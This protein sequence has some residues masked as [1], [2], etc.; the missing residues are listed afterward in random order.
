MVKCHL[1]TIA[2]DI[3][4]NNWFSFCFIRRFLIFILVSF[5]NL[6]S[7]QSFSFSLYNNS[8]TGLQNPFCSETA[9]T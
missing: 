4:G 2:S 9:P 8:W 1:A 7:T 6:D 3:K 5:S